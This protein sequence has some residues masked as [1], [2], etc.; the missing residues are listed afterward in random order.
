MKSVKADTLPRKP[1]DL[2]HTFETNPALRT[3]IEW[4]TLLLSQVCS[5]LHPSLVSYLFVWICTPECKC[6]R[7]NQSIFKR[8][9]RPI[10]TTE[11]KKAVEIGRGIWA[12]LL[13]STIT[14]NH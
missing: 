7:G 9:K 8:K 6:R 12:E 10:K 13:H 14:V 3:E 5:V 1:E 2:S 11:T 4:I